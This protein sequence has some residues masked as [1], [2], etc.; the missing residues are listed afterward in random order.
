MNILLTNDD[1]IFVPGL[2]ALHAALR[3]WGDVTVVAPR[4]E[5]SGISHAIT[6]RTPISAER[7]LLDG[8]VGGY[9]VSGTPADC[10]KFGVLELLE[11][12]P[13]VVVS[14][15]NL[16]LNVGHNVFYSGTVAAAIEGAMNGILSV[17]F[18]S[19]P[20]NADQLDRVAAEALR[21]LK[22]ILELGP[23][24]ALAYNV[25][26]PSLRDGEPEIMFTQQGAV[27]F[28]ERYRGGE[29]RGTYQLHI[30]TGVHR[31]PNEG[32]DEHAVEAGMISVTPLRADLTD[33]D[34]LRLLERSAR[35]ES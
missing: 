9:A 15:I 23:E 30:P 26:L 18:S 2:W 8:S 35:P 34:S 33:Q 20:S 10:V 4:A 21:V 25:N 19:C 5:Q 28:G 7:V 1:G 11:E 17:A 12:P 3:E 32:C 29:G 13:D 31:R 14:G 16:G 6:Y 22:M 27:P 24:T